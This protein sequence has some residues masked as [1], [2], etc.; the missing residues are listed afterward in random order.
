[1]RTIAVGLVIAFTNAYALGGTVSFTPDKHL[2]NL[3][4]GDSMIVTF[5]L[6]IASLDKLPGGTFDGMDAVVGSNDGLLV[7]DFVISPEVFTASFFGTFADVLNPGPGKYASDIKFG[8]FAANP[9]VL[10][11]SLSYPLGTLTVDASGLGPGSYQVVIDSDFDQQSFAALGLPTEGLFGVG[12]VN[13]VVPEPATM[14]LLGLASLAL[15][16]RRRKA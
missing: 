16:R 2:I 3:E 5:D 15:V 8:F 10:P 7:T 11:L 13:I 9:D 12:T 1:M 14:T 4:A 6:A